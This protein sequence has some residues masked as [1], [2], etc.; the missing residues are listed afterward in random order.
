MLLFHQARTCFAICCFLTGSR[1]SSSPDLPLRKAV[2]RKPLVRKL[3]YDEAK[4]RLGE[5]SRSATPRAGRVVPKP[6]V[7]LPQF[8]F[9]PLDAQGTMFHCL[10]LP[11]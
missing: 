5:K 4:N 9:S 3:K 11:I 7:R 10:N 2:K 8:C 6:S 1:H